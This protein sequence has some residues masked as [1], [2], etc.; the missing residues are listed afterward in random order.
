LPALYVLLFLLAFVLIGV[1]V[2]FNARRRK[3]LSTW[4]NARGFHFAS[5]RVRHFDDQH[6]EF[7]CLQRGHSRYAYNI[8]Q[9]AQGG[10]SVMAFDYHYATGSGKHRHDYRFSG[11]LLS[12][13]VALKPLAIRPENVLDKVSEFFGADDIDFESAAF[14]RRFHVTGPDKRWAYD[15]IHQR[16]MEFLLSMPVFSI[17]FGSRSVLVWRSRRFSSQSFD[18]AIEVAGG[19]LDRLPDYVLRQQKGVT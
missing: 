6:S 15:V 11:V 17:E 8:S 9:G 7:R 5:T 3:E 16:T 4:A 19:I 18:E 12:S 10:R 14:S 2:W 13:D 1:G